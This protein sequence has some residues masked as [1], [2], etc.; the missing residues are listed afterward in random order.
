MLHEY[1][2][3]KIFIIDDY[4]ETLKK[5]KEAEIFSDVEN[6]ERMK[7]TRGDRHK[8]HLSDFEMDNSVQKDYDLKKE[9]RNKSTNVAPDSENRKIVTEIQ[10]NDY[11]EKHENISRKRIHDDSNNNSNDS[12]CPAMKTKNDIAETNTIKK[13]IN[14]PYAEEIIVPARNNY[15]ESY[16]IMHIYLCILHNTDVLRTSR[17]FKD[18]V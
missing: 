11:S 14:I 1:C 16:F 17:C 7:K 10:N 8:K 15:G 18:V 12:C 3:I 5:R 2:L 13:R 4:N 6:E 9:T